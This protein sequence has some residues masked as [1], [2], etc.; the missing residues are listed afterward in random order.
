MDEHACAQEG[1]SLSRARSILKAKSPLISHEIGSKWDA[2]KDI[3]QENT[4]RAYSRD[5]RGILS[6]LDDNRNIKASSVKTNG[7]QKH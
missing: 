5:I 6:L 4:K 3:L 1:K 2:I 7:W